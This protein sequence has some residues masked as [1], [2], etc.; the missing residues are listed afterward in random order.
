[1]RFIRSVKI[2]WERVGLDFL[3]LLKMKFSARMGR[4]RK[5]NI[6][7]SNKDMATETRLVSARE[8]ISKPCVHV[9]PYS[10]VLLRNTHKMDVLCVYTLVKIRE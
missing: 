7:P 5:I 1:M 9:R 4:L 8:L 6:A 3:A 10:T 2:S